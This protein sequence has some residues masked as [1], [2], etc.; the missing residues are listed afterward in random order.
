MTTTTGRSNKTT[1]FFWLSA[2]IVASSSVLL[3]YS[4]CNHHSHG[5]LEEQNFLARVAGILYSKHYHHRHHH[6]GGG[7]GVDGCDEGDWKDRSKKLVADYDVSLVLSVDIRGCGKFSSVQKAVEAVPDFSPYRTL[8][9]VNSG[10]YREKVVVNASKVNLILLGQGY[11]NTAIVWNDTAN[12]TG[13]SI[14]S[15]SVAIFSPNFTAYNIGFQNTAPE[16]RPGE[17]GAQGIALRIAGDAAAFYGCGFYG[18]QDTLYDDQGRHYFREC[19]IQGSIDIIFGNGRSLYEGCTIN[20]IAKDLGAEVSGSITAQGRGS[21]SEGT[22][23]SFVQCSING[24]GR[25]WLGRAW[26]AYATVVFSKTYMSDVISPEGWNDWGDSSRD[27]TVFFGEYDC[28]GP[29]ANYTNRVPY[30]RQLTESEAAPYLDTSYI[31]GEEWLP[32][33]HDIQLASY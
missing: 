19:F 10:T 18:A 24:T 1:F 26:N 12:S 17:S 22:G 15:A 2:S 8:I 3:Y 11:L 29:G 23:F 30:A 21:S 27:Q 14:Y 13:G 33:R 31:D 6:R 20:S 4:L 7:P 28:W 5:L 16:P 9:L 32:T 25:V